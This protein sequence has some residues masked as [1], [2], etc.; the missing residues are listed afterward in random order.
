MQVGRLLFLL[1]HKFTRG[2]ALEQ[3]RTATLVHDLYPVM[4]EKPPIGA[5]AS[6]MTRVHESAPIHSKG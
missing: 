2:R 6:R 5:L 3:E 1:S 4:H